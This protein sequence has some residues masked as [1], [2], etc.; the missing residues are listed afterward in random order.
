MVL[1]HAAG[2]AALWEDAVTQWG[3]GSLTLLEVLGPAIELAEEGFPVSP[4][5]AYDW[6]RAVPVLQEAAAAGGP[7]GLA[8]VRWGAAMA[9]PLPCLCWQLAPQS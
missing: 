2:A 7:E 1:W 9:S 3:S 8:A 4:M 5:A 6:G